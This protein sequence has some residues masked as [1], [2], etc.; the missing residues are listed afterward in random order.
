LKKARR[1]VLHRQILKVVP[2]VRQERNGAVPTALF[3]AQVGRFGNGVPSGRA[4]STVCRAACAA[5]GDGASSRVNRSTASSRW[6]STSTRLMVG[7]MGVQS[8][9]I[10]P[11]PPVSSSTA[12]RRVGKRSSKASFSS[13]YPRISPRMSGRRLMP[14]AAFVEACRSHCRISS[15]CMS[16]SLAACTEVERRGESR[17][18]QSSLER[19]GGI[20]RR[21]KWH[22]QR[23]AGHEHGGTKGALLCPK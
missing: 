13:A 16:R 15:V 4:S 21:W 12:S 2:V 11:H 9:S 10:V 8:R 19:E 1:G 6:K 5:S 20:I 23:R 18:V 17:D 3:V 7:F 14:S 22:D